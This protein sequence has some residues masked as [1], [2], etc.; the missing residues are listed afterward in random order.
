MRFTADNQ[1]FESEIAPFE[2]KLF[3]DIL[4]QNTQLLQ[5]FPEF[6]FLRSAVEKG[7]RVILADTDHHPGADK[8]ICR[9]F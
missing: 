4:I 2:Q 3:A 8:Q 9:L 7:D 6:L 1:I 5:I